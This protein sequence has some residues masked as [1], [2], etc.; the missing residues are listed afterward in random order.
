MAR[1]VAELTNP[2]HAV[3]IDAAQRTRA[4]VEVVVVVMVMMVME[5]VEVIARNGRRVSEK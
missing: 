4:V 2:V 1:P 5:E 3:G